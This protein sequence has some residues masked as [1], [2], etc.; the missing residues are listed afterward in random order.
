MIRT[1][2]ALAPHLESQLKARSSLRQQQDTPVDAG[3]VCDQ[4]TQADTDPFSARCAGVTMIQGKGRSLDSGRAFSRPSH[5]GV[6]MPIRGPGTAHLETGARFPQT[7]PGFS[8]RPC[9]DTE[10]KSKH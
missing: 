9:L 10:T 2:P 4:A 7:G 1:L 8:P 6:E 5:P 3:D